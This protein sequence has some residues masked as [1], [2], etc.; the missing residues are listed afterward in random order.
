MEK[1]TTLK[2]QKALVT[3]AATGIGRACVMAL[4]ASGAAV[5]VNYLDQPEKANQVAKQAAEEHGVQSLAV[6][7]DVSQESDVERMFSE[8]AG[9][10]GRLDILV[11]NA[12]IQSDAS[13]VDM[14]L[15]QWQKVL[16][17]NL[18]GAFLCS[19]AAVRQFLEQDAVAEQ[20]RSVGKIVFT[21]SVHQV[22]PWSGHANYAASKGGLM[23]LMK[24]IAQ[25][26]ADKKIR[27]NAVAPGAIKTDINRNAWEEENTAEELRKL[28]PYGRI[29]ETADIGPLVAWLSSDAADYIT[30]TTLFI[31]G[32]MLLY[33]G[34]RTG[35]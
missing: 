12:G 7:A 3:G 31:D 32:G 26:F 19:R 35:G 24:S 27:V 1:S 33:P 2:G 34:F 15:D 14:T 17:V 29:G 18:T 4:A 25:E 9:A 22:I 11:S 16:D 8:V 30:G 20:S 28:I 23:L 13:F 10:F 6:Q 5:A 21:S